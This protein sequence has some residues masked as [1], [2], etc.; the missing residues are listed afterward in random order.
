MRHGNAHAKHLPGNGFFQKRF[1][2]LGEYA[3]GFPWQDDP[4]GL[5]RTARGIEDQGRLV[6]LDGHILDRWLT[7]KL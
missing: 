4:F 1:A 3:Q 5:S 2:E 7:L 6:G